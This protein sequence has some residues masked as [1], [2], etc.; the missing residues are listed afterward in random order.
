MS[1]FPKSD[2]SA[3]LAAYL[4]L[5]QTAVSDQQDDE[6]GQYEHVLAT[7]PI[8]S[9]PDLRAKARYI[10]HCHALDPALVPKSAVDTLVVGIETLSG[11]APHGR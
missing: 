7:A 6:L 2:L 5:S 4:V 8:T 11:A 3:T 10:R 1:G 9:W